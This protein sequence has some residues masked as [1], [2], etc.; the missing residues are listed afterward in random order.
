MNT[1]TSPSATNVSTESVA[2]RHLDE[3]IHEYAI[4]PIADFVDETATI[5]SL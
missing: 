4:S 1:T 2:H 3:Q 5:A